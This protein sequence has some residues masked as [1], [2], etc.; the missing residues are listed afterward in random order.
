MYT[1][2]KLLPRQNKALSTLTPINEQGLKGL[3]ALFR[4]L[5]DASRLQILMMLA[6]NGEM[7]VSAIGDRLT[8]SQPAISHHLNQLKRVG[9]VDFRRDGKF[10]FYRLDPEGLTRLTEVL[11]PGGGDLNLEFGF[12][13]DHVQFEVA[14]DSMD[15]T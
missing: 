8:Q 4:G 10:N 14:L 15:S 1:G 13:G 9:L 6:E 2:N 11:F 5:A 12:A 7:N 3:T